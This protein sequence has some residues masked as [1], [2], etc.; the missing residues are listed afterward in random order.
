M[1]YGFGPSHVLTRPI[2]VTKAAKNP[3]QRTEMKMCINV[4]S[5]FCRIFG[6]LQ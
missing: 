2:S 6:A 4:Q 5:S 3:F 1:N